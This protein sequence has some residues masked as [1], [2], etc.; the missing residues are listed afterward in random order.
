MNF[1][2]VNNVSQIVVV[3]MERL[4]LQCASILEKEGRY[5]N[6]ACGTNAITYRISPV[7]ISNSSTECYISCDGY[8]IVAELDQSTRQR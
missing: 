3:A 1:V 8:R 4:S 2:D 7:I 6:Y 5:H